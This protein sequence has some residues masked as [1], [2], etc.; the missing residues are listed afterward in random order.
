MKLKNNQ[1]YQNFDW[2]IIAIISIIVAYSLLILANASFNPYNETGVSSIFNTISRIDFKYV[3]LQLGFYIIGLGAMFA[4]LFLDYHTLGEYGKYIYFINCVVLVG[5]LFFAK[6]TRGVRGWI[7]VFGFGF[8]PAEI[9]KITIIIF[10]GRMIAKKIDE[11]GDTP[12]G[13]KDLLPI[14]GYFLVPFV[15]VMLQPDWGTAMVF[16]CVFLGMILVA[17]IYKKVIYTVLGSLAVLLP[18]AWL[19]MADWQRSRILGFLTPGGAGVDQVSQSK[20]LIGS[21]Q[22]FGK[23]FFQEGSL[24]Q[25]DFLAEKHTDFIFASAAET[26]G[27]VGGLL[28]LLL[29]FGLLFRLLYLAKKSSDTYGTIIIIGVLSMMIFHVFENIAMTMGIMPV[30]GIPAP[31][32]SYGGSSMLTNMIAIGLVENVVIRRFKKHY[33]FNGISYKD[34][35]KLNTGILNNNKIKKTRRKPIS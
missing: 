10:L 30:T 12:L 22:F 32:F 3:F 23:G 1:Y 6:S 14:V 15:L 24:A 35:P 21:G 5:L 18:L 33:E 25:L 16:V 19:L 2:P 11:K 31:F 27:F 28:L 29:Y 7:Y 17:K 8:Q 26:L 13:F 9:C 4:L 20:V 34:K